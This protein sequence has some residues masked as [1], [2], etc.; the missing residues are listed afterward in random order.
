MNYDYMA[1]EHVNRIC[2]DT[3]PLWFAR[4]HWRLKQRDEDWHA[5]ILAW[6]ETGTNPQS[7]CIRG[8]IGQGVTTA[9][10]SHSASYPVC[11]T[12]KQCKTAY[13]PFD[14]VT[15]AHFAVSSK[16]PQNVIISHVW[17]L[18][19]TKLTCI[20]VLSGSCSFVQYKHYAIGTNSIHHTTSSPSSPL[21]PSMYV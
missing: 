10:M 13:S 3:T 16:S 6:I 20:H 14:V 12:G 15:G 11:M 9:Y 7:A 8:C 21:L 18:P 1:A 19:L 2:M 4:W 17:S 5:D